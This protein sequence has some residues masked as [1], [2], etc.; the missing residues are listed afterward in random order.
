MGSR[1]INPSHWPRSHLP[2]PMTQPQQPRPFHKRHIRAGGCVRWGMAVAWN[3]YKCVAVSLPERLRNGRFTSKTAVW[4]FRSEIATWIQKRLKYPLGLLGGSYR[5]AATVLLAVQARVS[6]K[7]RKRD[8]RAAGIQ[9]GAGGMLRRFPQ[10]CGC[11]A[12]VRGGS[13]VWSRGRALLLFWEVV[14][15]ALQNR[16]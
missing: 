13:A 8:A 16:A 12:V 11:S 15:V 3:R 9:V 14:S 5:A 1:D 6:G 10:R 4:V 7:D 2:S